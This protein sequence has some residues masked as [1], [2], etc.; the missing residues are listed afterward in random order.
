M[1][2]INW[3]ISVPSSVTAG[4]TV[5]VTVNVSYSGYSASL[6]VRATVILFGQTQ[7]KEALLP[8]PGI[9]FPI[10]FSFT[11]PDIEDRYA[12]SAKLEVYY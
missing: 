6:R 9:Y 12:G 10:T 11:A 4:S 2:T 1:V 3:S 7:V 5:P 8:E